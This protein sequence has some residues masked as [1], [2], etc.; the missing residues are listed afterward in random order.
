[1]GSLPLDFTF[2][3][4]SDPTGGIAV[5]VTRGS[6]WE[7]FPE[8]LQHHIKSSGQRLRRAVI[9]DVGSHVRPCRGFILPIGVNADGGFVAV[10]CSRSDFPTETDQLL[11]SVAVITLRQDSKAHASSTSATVRRK[12]FAKLAPKRLCARHGASLH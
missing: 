7:G 4:L 5:D 12:N 2:V 6:A 8:W 11:L 9:A 1:M 3:R 10:A